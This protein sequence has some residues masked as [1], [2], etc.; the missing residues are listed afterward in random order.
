MRLVA[1]RPRAQPRVECEVR[2]P[3]RQLGAQRV[4]LV[5]GRSGGGGRLRSTLGLVLVDVVFAVERRRGSGVVS[6]GAQLLGRPGRAALE[7]R[8]WQHGLR[9]RSSW[10]TV[11]EG[12]QAARACQAYYDTPPQASN[13]LE[14][15]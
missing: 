15:R 1:A 9:A 4:E 10:S 5:R 8:L 14:N 12:T 7:Q 3:R 11:K 6:G 2:T 13:G